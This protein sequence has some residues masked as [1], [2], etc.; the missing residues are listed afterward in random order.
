M[1]RPA[2][3]SDDQAVRRTAILAI[4]VSDSMA[5]AE[6]QRRPRRPRRPSST[7][8]PPTCTSASS[9]SPAGHRAAAADAGP[10][11]VHAGWST[12]SRCPTAPT[13][14]TA[15]GRPPAPAA[16]TGQRSVIVLSDGR[17]TSTTPLA[18]VPARS[19]SRGVKVDVVALAQS[20]RD[21]SLLAPLSDGRRRRSS[22]PP[23]RTRSRQIF[24]SE[25]QA[26]ASQ[27][28]VTAHRPRGRHDRGHA[29]RRPRRG[30][31]RRT[32]TRPSCPST[33]TARPPGRGGRH[34]LQPRR[35]GHPARPRARCSPACSAS[36]SACWCSCVGDVRRPR[37]AAG[38]HRGP[39]RGLHGSR[40]VAARA[41]ARQPG[42]GLR[43]S[44]W[45]QKALEGNQGFEAKLGV[46]A[47]RRRADAEAGRVAAAARR[48][49]LGA[50]ALV[51]FL[52]TGGDMCS[53]C[54]ALVAGRR[55]PVDLPRLQAVPSAQG[56]Q[57]PARRDAAADRGQPPGRT[58]GGPGAWTPSCARG[59]AGRR[60][61]PPRPGRDPARRADR[62]RP[63]ARWPSGWRAR[64]SSGPS[65]RSASSARSA[66]TWPSCCSRWRPPCAS[67]STSAAR[68]SP[69]RPKAG[70]RPTSCSACRPASSCYVMIA[71]R[72]YLI[73]CSTTRSAGS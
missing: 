39:H 22:A 69:C 64:T 63:R 41:A 6:V 18:T 71:N 21:E 1:P 67:A 52:L 45:P 34:R 61:V 12:A 27:V 50:A 37:Q 54:V 47:G 51:A 14:T 57:L 15:S 19:R 32:P 4:D 26:L 10:C 29:G 7:R 28:L 48:H 3:A 25:A 16:R 65:W 35:P 44:A 49:R 38:L 31:T 55:G 5:A 60:R 17:D 30:G 56:V 9:P 24:T 40:R 20:A 73:R 42:D 70:S 68:S 46:E 72:A 36:G 58:L 13:C 66:A 59:R 11:A 2:L 43:R 62:G 53:S 8:C 23:T 33:G